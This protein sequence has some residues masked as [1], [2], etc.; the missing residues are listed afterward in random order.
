MVFFHKFVKELL[1][2]FNVLRFGCLF[3]DED[4]NEGITYLESDVDYITLSDRVVD[5][6]RQTL[7]VYVEHAIPKPEMFPMEEPLSNQNAIT[8]I[9]MYMKEMVDL[10]LNEEGIR[11]EIGVDEDIDI[12]SDGGAK[13]EHISNDWN[14]NEEMVELYPL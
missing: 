1:D 13:N 4:F 7:H 2:D 12:E 11:G 6:W 10:N 5:K 14:T 8:V 9:Q 3:D